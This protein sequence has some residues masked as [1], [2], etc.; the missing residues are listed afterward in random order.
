[1]DETGR[2]SA[3]KLQKKPSGKSSNSRTAA[4]KVRINKMP[5]FA[6]CPAATITTTAMGEL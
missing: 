3:R 6:F 4:T 5:G 2:S 1:M